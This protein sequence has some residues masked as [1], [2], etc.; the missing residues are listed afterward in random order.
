MDDRTISIRLTFDEAA[1]LDDLLRR[2]S[3]TDVFSIV[4][5][6]ERHALWN[7]A[8]LLERD[9]DRPFWPDLEEAR[10][11]LRSGD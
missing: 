3:T 11:A 6:A 10:T 5:E 8:C 1:V 9:G 2:Y 4:D 7:L